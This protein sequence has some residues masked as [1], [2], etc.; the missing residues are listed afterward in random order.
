MSR[1]FGRLLV[2]HDVLATHAA[3]WDNLSNGILSA[4]AAGDAFTAFITVDKNL[5]HQQ[6]SAQLPRPVIVIDSLGNN[7]LSLVPYAPEA[8][9][10]LS[11]HLERRACVI[12]RCS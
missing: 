2:G 11:Q 9:R 4:S 10:L 7:V 3:G 1:K 12:Q 6:Y 8:L 5:R